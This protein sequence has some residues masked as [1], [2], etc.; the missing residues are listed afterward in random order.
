MQGGVSQVDSF[1]YKPLLEKRDGEQISFDDPREFA[2]SG[3]LGSKQKIMKSLW[4]FRQRGESGRWVSDLF[5]EM[6]EHVDKMA[7]IHSMNT[8]GLP[9]VQRHSF[10][11]AAH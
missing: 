7:F 9:T 8:E 4:P 2:N 11:I 5:P 1:D 3:T 10:F 6:G